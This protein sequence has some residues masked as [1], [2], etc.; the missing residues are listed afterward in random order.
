MSD[1]EKNN[2]LLQK[3]HW[4]DRSKLNRNTKTIRAIV[5]EILNQLSPQLNKIHGVNESQ[6]YWDIV[7]GEWSFLFAQ[8]IFDRWSSV[9]SLL[10]L[11]IDIEVISKIGI[12]NN[13]P[14]DTRE[15]LTSATMSDEWNS[16]LF[17][18]I[19]HAILKKDFEP[20]ERNLKCINARKKETKFSFKTGV[21]ILV[22][23]I[24][25]W[26]SKLGNEI[27]IQNIYLK[28]IQLLKFSTIIRQIPY[29]ETKVFL[30]DLVPNS[31][32]GNIQMELTTLKDLADAELAAV[33]CKLLPKY[34]PQIYLEQ[35]ASHKKK[36]LKVYQSRIPR[37][38][39][40][41]NS[42]SLNEEWK[43]W[44]AFAC[45]NGSKLAIL[46]HGGMYGANQYS[47]IQEYELM[48]CDKFLTWGWEDPTN[49][50]IMSSHP[51]KLMGLSPR[52]DRKSRTRITFIAFEMPLHSYWLASMPVGPQVIDSAL[53][54]L[55]FIN[56]LK[57]ELLHLLKV[58]PYPT[59]YGLNAKASYEKLLLK[60]QILGGED[61]SFDHA[62]SDSRIVVSNYN[63]T[64]Y[65]QS[66][67][68]N[69]P[70]V[71]FWDKEL[72]EINS[73]YANIFQ[74]LHSARVLFYSAKECADFVNSNYESIEDWWS[75]D[76]VRNSIRNFLKIFGNI[77]DNSL[78]AFAKQIVSI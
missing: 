56:S 23:Q 28:N 32:I 37:L 35:F 33:V 13:S 19:T 27:L 34:F 20:L 65:I 53:S 50:K 5:D 59:N 31:K 52:K 45:S 61:E 8:V 43:K 15:F 36:S 38:I 68:L 10:N 24:S 1:F 63:G 9:T 74:E 16:N 46:Q 6:R 21:K 25:G 7:I 14:I 76:E 30:S 42:Y 60:E 62:I 72:W 70:T 11:E 44:A 17:E 77:D 71:I 67:A 40:T 4:D 73:R 47:L 18:E 58:R 49:S 3:Y 69:V 55:E 64:V 29:F 75:T 26:K 22:N 12:P 39:A 48:I 78:F 41:A 54:S 66:M 2:L 57:N 51:T